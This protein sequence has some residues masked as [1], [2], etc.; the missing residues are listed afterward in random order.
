[1]IDQR[2]NMY[3]EVGGFAL[4]S[5]AQL[6]P[7]LRRFF[8]RIK[9]GASAV[10]EITVASLSTTPFHANNEQLRRTPD[11]LDDLLTDDDIEV[12]DEDIMEHEVLLCLC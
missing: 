4:A 2:V 5:R 11:A 1:M 9:D 10:A 8:F 3:F 6:M 7:I 12:D